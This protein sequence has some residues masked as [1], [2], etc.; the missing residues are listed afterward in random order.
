[1]N[2]IVEIFK[3]WGI[4]FNPDDK[5]AELAAQRMEVCDSCNFKKTTPVIHCGQ[6]GCALKAKIYSPV[7]G[8]CP[9]GK[10]NKVD[11]DYFQAKFQYEKLKRLEKK[12]LEEEQNNK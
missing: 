4:A 9:E 8:A 11:N 7:N 2:K 12:R 10:W 1:M 3:A 6:C 5:Q